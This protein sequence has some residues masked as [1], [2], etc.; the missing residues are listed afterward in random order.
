MDY[1]QGIKKHKFVRD[2]HGTYKDARSLLDGLLGILGTRAGGDPSQSVTWWMTN[3]PDEEIV[4]AY[5]DFVTGLDQLLNYREY[6]EHLI[7]GMLQE[8]GASVMRGT[9]GEILS[10]DPNAYIT[11][12]SEYE[13]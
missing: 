9:K 12:P 1:I 4:D 11:N 13:N 2:D 6:F 10:S 5:V 7:D 3:K 8:R